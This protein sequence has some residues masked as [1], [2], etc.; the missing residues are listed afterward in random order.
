[1]TKAYDPWAHAQALGLVIIEQR[2][3]HGRR[4]E[5]R[6]AER[7]IAMLPGLTEREARSVLAHEV[8][9]ALRGDVPSPSNLISARQELHARRAAARM[10]I[11][12]VEYAAAEQLRGP[13]LAS[14]AYELNVS[15]HV[16]DDWIAMHAAMVAAC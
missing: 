13:H 7:T 3:Q 9:H 2:L 14:I 4:G 8:Q 11:D 5:Y 15:I 16:V 12:P 10:L 1:M 6:H